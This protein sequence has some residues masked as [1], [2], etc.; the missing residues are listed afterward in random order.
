MERARV[1]GLREARGAGPG[2]AGFVRMNLTLYIAKKDEAMWLTAKAQR[3]NMSAL[4]WYISC[5]LRQA[6]EKDKFDEVT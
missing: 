6:M 5:L 4:S 2:D 3:K 1:A